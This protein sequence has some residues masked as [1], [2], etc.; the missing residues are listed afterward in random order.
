MERYAIVQSMED[1]A[2]KGRT[3]VSARLVESDGKEALRYSPG[4]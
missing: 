1:A 4:T 2:Y 3:H